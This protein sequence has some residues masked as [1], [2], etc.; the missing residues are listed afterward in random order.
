MYVPRDSTQHTTCPR[1][2]TIYTVMMGC[3]GG[4]ARPLPWPGPRPSIRS[5]SSSDWLTRISSSFH[6]FPRCCSTACSPNFCCTNT[7]QWMAHQRN[8][9]I[10]PSFV[11]CVRVEQMERS[12]WKKVPQRIGLE[13]IIIFRSCFNFRNLSFLINFLLLRSFVYSL[14]RK[15]PL[16]QQLSQ[17]NELRTFHTWTS[18][19]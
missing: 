17:P 2:I 7:K 13:L 5:S 18:L 8:F 14:W 16:S 10:T 11:D 4:I 1:F 15:F 9:V 12:G 19:F 3:L 6:V